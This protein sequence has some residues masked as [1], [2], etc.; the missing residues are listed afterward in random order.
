[1]AAAAIRR[2]ALIL[3]FAVPH[4]LRSRQSMSRSGASPYRVDPHPVSDDNDSRPL[5]ALIKALPLSLASPPGFPATDEQ[6]LAEVEERTWIAQFEQEGAFNALVAA[7]R[8][9]NPRVDD[10]ALI[11][12]FREGR[13]GAI[14]LDVQ[15]LTDIHP[16]CSAWHGAPAL[17]GTAR[18]TTSRIALHASSAAAG[19]RHQL[20][21]AR[22][23]I[24][25]TPMPVFVLS[26]LHSV[27]GILR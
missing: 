21:A 19:S 1:M 8:R 18:G 13:G 16:R 15:R 26:R 20:P 9:K 6:G 23:Q 12:P 2:M 24:R 5:A 7:Q 10:L 3:A 27:L 11:E 22:L 17:D 14:S 25:L 4:R